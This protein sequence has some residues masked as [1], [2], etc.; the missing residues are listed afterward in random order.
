MHALGLLFTVLSVSASATRC[1]VKSSVLTQ[2]LKINGFEVSYK[3]VFI[4]Y[5]KAPEKC[6]FTIIITRTTYYVCQ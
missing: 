4:N 1:L 3:A 2:S 6:W 5:S